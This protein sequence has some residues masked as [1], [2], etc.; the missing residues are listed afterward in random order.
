MALRTLLFSPQAELSARPRSYAAL[1]DLP[2]ELTRPVPD[3]ARVANRA[4]RPYNFPLLGPSRTWRLFDWAP[5]PP[6]D[7]DLAW[8]GIDFVV[9]RGSLE[10]CA[11]RPGWQ[12]LYQ[13]RAASLELWGAREGDVMTL[14]AVRRQ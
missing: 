5:R 10:E 9:C 2:P 14:H 3:G 6:S 11:G 13:G 4:G 12:L 7:Q 8:H 1:Y